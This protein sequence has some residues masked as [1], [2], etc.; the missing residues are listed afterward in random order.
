MIHTLYW[1]QRLEIKVFWEGIHL[2][3]TAK[4]QVE[5]LPIGG[6]PEIVQ[7]SA[8]SP[9]VLLFVPLFGLMSRADTHYLS[10]REGA[11]VRRGVRPRGRV[12]FSQQ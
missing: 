6:S 11:F 1:S 8:K 12:L 5:L 2:Q 4:C 3:N 10:P 7:V 9:E